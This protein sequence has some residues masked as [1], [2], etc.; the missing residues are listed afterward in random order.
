MNPAKAISSNGPIPTGRWEFFVWL[1]GQFAKGG[2]VA[3]VLLLILGMGG[4][5]LDK[6]LS[7]QNAILERLATG[8]A[9]MQVAIA[10]K[11]ETIAVNH[12]L[13][14]RGEERD[15]AIVAALEKG[16]ILAAHMGDKMD[17]ANQLMAGAP[18]R[19]EKTVALL[20]SLVEEL[21]ETRKNQPTPP[22]SNDGGA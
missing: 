9:Q 19:G 6:Y 15:K 12:E 3:L 11:N 10:A 1:C 16:N 14:I 8:Q 22:R 4:Y 7:N 20:Q 13:L 18:A 21:K 17:E 5:G 2:P